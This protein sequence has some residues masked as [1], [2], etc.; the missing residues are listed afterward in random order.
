MS[1]PEPLSAEA[2]AL[3]SWATKAARLAPKGKFGRELRA[4][5]ARLDA[6]RAVSPD[7]APVPEGLRE[8]VKAIVL[9]LTLSIDE[10]IDA[11]TA[12]V[13]PAA[14]DRTEGL[15]VEDVRLLTHA[16]T[17]LLQDHDCDRH[18]WE[19]LA[20]ANRRVRAAIKEQSR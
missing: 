7:P 10:T 15:D 2:E 19:T 8:R 18:G 13:T 17:H 16:V 14:P 20:E 1:E 3:A 6:A 9:D 4:R 12:L 5:L 11:L